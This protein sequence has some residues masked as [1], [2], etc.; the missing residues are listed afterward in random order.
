MT[1]RTIDVLILGAG[2]AGSALALALK[3]LGIGDV[4]MIDSAASRSMHIGEA[5]APGLNWLLR[6]LGLDD[7]LEARG[8]RPCHG[9]RSAW[10]SATCQVTDFMTGARG[11]GWHLDRAAFD[12]WLLEETIEAGAEIVSPARLEEAHWEADR[13]QAR[14]HH[15]DM[16]MRLEVRW[17]VDATGRPAAFARRHG[18]DLHRLDRLIALAM[19]AEPDEGQGFDSYSQIEAVECGWWYAATLSGGKTL[20]SL[21]TD[22]DIVRARG[23]ATGKGFMCAFQATR[24]ICRIAR[25]NQVTPKVF[26]AGSQFIDRAIAPGWLALGDALMAFDPLS[27]SGITGAI[28]DAV[29]V[30]E[31]LL[32]LLE[33]PSEEEAKDLR[34]GY[35]ARANAGLDR[36]LREHCAI[37]AAE[38]RWPESLFWRRRAA[39]T[40][41]PA[42]MPS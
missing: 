41:R 15:R 6:R 26:A 36:F 4:L 13:W 25:P 20:I 8:H 5:A 19:L 42:S 31:L 27:A 23:L 32:V 28:E 34:R 9:N 33:A 7:R 10:G 16:T 29:A 3:R 24:E 11:P 1:T 18:A 30:S 35:A 2:P 12:A 17:I 14:L 37:Y 40:A 21:M 38:Q 39:H 22:S